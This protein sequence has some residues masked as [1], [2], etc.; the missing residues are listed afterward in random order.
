MAHVVVSLRMRWRERE[1]ETNL[2]SLPRLKDDRK[3]D[4]LIKAFLC[5]PTYINNILLLKSF[6]FFSF[7][8]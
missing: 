4:Q 5:I 8:H 3:T 7:L 6:H 2:D 1:R